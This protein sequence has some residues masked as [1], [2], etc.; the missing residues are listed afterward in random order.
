MLCKRVKVIAQEYRVDLTQYSWSSDTDKKTVYVVCSTRRLGGSTC[1]VGQIETEEIHVEAHQVVASDH[2]APGS[3]SR[4]LYSCRKA[5]NAASAIFT[6]S[7]AAVACIATDQ[8]APPGLKTVTAFCPAQL[9]AHPIASYRDTGRKC[10]NCRMWPAYGYRSRWSDSGKSGGKTAKNRRGGRTGILVVSGGDYVP[11][12]LPVLRQKMRERKMKAGKTDCQPCN[13]ISG[14]T[15]PIFLFLIFSV[16]LIWNQDRY[17]VLAYRI[18]FRCT[19]M[20]RVAPLTLLVACLGCQW[21]M[22]RDPVPAS[23]KDSAK[24][25]QRGQRLD[26]AKAARKG[27]AMSGRGR[28]LARRTA[29]PGITMPRAL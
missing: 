4:S 5:A 19:S 28:R 26:G 23:L 15:L 11:A 10:P 22:L 29:T 2:F 24:A 17:S 20:H 3:A 21:A 1:G 8:K 25:L 14:D 13:Y 7:V 27:R 6:G 16:G 9:P 18:S 12:L